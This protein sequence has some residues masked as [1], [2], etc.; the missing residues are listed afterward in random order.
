MPPSVCY[1]CI[2]AN[3]CLLPSATEH[4]VLQPQKDKIQNYWSNFLPPFHVKGQAPSLNL[5]FKM[6][7]TSEGLT[8]YTFMQVNL[9]RTTRSP[10]RAPFL[11]PV[12]S[13]S[14]IF[15]PIPFFRRRH[16]C[17]SCFTF[18]IWYRVIESLYLSDLVSVQFATSLSSITESATSS[19]SLI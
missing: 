18:E 9:I 16:I 5:L 12:F 6:G 19:T 8:L 13:S 4:Q 15:N 17:T 3:P 10:L 2:Q 14:R 7:F 11:S 1:R